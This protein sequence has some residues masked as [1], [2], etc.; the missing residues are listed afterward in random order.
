MLLSCQQRDGRSFWPP[1][2][3]G[4]TSL[5]WFHLGVS[6]LRTPF[7]GG[8]TQTKTQGTTE[9]FWELRINISSELLAQRISSSAASG[10]CSSAGRP[11]KSSLCTFAPSQLA[12]STSK[13]RSGRRF[14]SDWIEN[15]GQRLAKRNG[16]CFTPV[17]R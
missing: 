2:P 4:F 14:R 1:P 17:L 16:R 9:S 6:L 13:F 8:S 10:A 3:A 12:T 5:L 15:R 11:R 7:W